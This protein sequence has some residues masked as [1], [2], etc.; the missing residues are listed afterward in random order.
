MHTFIVGMQKTVFL[1]PA[2]R[3]WGGGQANFHE[4]VKVGCINLGYL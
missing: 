2:Q 3:A 1:L 4:H